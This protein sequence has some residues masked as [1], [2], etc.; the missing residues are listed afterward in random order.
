M[1]RAAFE[2]SLK[3]AASNLSNKTDAT[4][5]VQLLKTTA[6]LDNQQL[7]QSLTEYIK[8]KA[9]QTSNDE[10]AQVYASL[11]LLKKELIDSKLLKVME[12][13]T[14]RRVH[15]IAMKEIS[16]IIYSYGYLCQQGKTQVSSS[17]VKTLEYVI[18]N[19]IHQFTQDQLSQCF[20]SLVRLQRASSKV[21]TISNQTLL[22]VYDR[23]SYELEDENK[24]I[25]TSLLAEVYY[26]SLSHH[27]LREEVDRVNVERRLMDEANQFKARDI[28]NVLSVT[29]NKELVEHLIQKIKDV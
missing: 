12:Y 18:M 15:G 24:K 13:L 4:T 25:K 19:K 17:F 28:F 6:F 21:K 1:Q 8:H 22:E 7:T 5:L 14:L 23:W 20:I 11:V 3:F 29:E 26:Q 10:L 27:S 9:S 16:S 2:D